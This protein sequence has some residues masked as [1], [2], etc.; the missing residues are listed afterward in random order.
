MKA[1]VFGEI[2]T[3]IVIRVS[4]LFPPGPVV[5]GISYLT[6]T[7]GRGANQAMSISRLGLT[8]YL[9]GRVGKDD[10]SKEILKRLKSANVYTDGIELDDGNPGLAI[11][12]V[13]D[14]GEFR[15]LAFVEGINEKIDHNDLDRFLKLMQQATVGL[16]QFGYPVWVISEAIKAAKSAGI[17]TI[18]DPTPIL[19]EIPSD[20]YSATD[21]ITPNGSEAEQLVGFPVTDYASALKASKSLHDL[22]TQTVIIKMGEFGAVC[23]TQVEQFHIPAFPVNVV[24]TIGAGDAFNGGLA[25][26]LAMGKSIK[27]AVI[28]GCA[29][30]ALSITG[31]GAQSALPNIE[32]LLQFIS[33]RS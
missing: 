13:D 22:G 32:T 23:S 30:G 24:D 17:T 4:D 6:T 26:A 20:L 33:E 16:F 1:I 29:A 31:L 25:A 12:T 27:E 7:G 21:I 15:V 5:R 3:D 28:W 9:V 14:V 18:L 2:N 19:T 10:F 11:L 8:T